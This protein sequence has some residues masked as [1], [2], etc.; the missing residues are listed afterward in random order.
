MPKHMSN[1]TDISM[2]AHEHNINMHVLTGLENKEKSKEKE[3]WESFSLNL[4]LSHRFKFTSIG[5]TSLGYKYERTLSFGIK[6]ND[7]VHSYWPHV[8]FTFLMRPN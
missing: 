3:D 6:N 5:Y 8:L 2:T 4:S 1:L 7:I